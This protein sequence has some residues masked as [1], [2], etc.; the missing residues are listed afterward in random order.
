MDT[1]G[2]SPDVEMVE[3]ETLFEALEQYITFDDNGVPVHGC[4]NDFR[5]TRAI[6]ASH[7]QEESAEEVIA[8]LN[9]QGAFCDCEVLLNSRID[10]VFVED[11]EEYEE[12]TEE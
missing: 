1:N 10:I 9:K 3:S 7:G 8:L 2:A 5:H 4:A 12:E 6:L 11:E